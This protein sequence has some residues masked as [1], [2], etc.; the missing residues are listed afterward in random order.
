MLGCLVWWP[1]TVITSYNAQVYL[2]GFKP[3][4]KGRDYL[5]RPW[6]GFGGRNGWNPLNALTT[7]VQR[8]YK[9]AMISA[10]SMSNQ[11]FGG[12]TDVGG[13]GRVVRRGRNTGTQRRQKNKR[14]VRTGKAWACVFVHVWIVIFDQVIENV[15]PVLSCC[16]LLQ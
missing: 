14:R 13:G 3:K 16:L 6:I 8:S 4:H 5:R 7:E 11:I 15:T 9:E 2:Y 12:D 10:K 1:W